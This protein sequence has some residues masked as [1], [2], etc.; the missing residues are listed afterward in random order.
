MTLMSDNDLEG[1]RAHEFIWKKLFDEAEAV[2][3]DFAH[4]GI[5]GEKDY[6][7]VD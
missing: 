3:K 7:L 5:I 6:W 1:I 2:L 4:K